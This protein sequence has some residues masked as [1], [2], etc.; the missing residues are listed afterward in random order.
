[1]SA[2][3]FWRFASSSSCTVYGRNSSAFGEITCFSV[4]SLLRLLLVGS[5]LILSSVLGEREFLLNVSINAGLLKSA[6]FDVLG[7]L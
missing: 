4:G 2:Q 3:L 6:L 1:M 5:R 7:L